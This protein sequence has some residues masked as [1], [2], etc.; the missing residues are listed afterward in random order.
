MI[1]DTNFLL[2]HYLVVTNAL[3][4]GVTDPKGWVL[5]ALKEGE[6]TIPD[7]LKKDDYMYKICV[8]FFTLEN[9]RPPKDEQEIKLWLSEEGKCHQKTQKPKESEDMDLSKKEERNCSENETTHASNADS[10]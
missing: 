6:H 2:F 7:F 4:N 9:N 8:N 5:F 3:S 1:S 10:Q